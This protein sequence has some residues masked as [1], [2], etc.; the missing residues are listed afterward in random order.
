MEKRYFGNIRSIAP[1]VVCPNICL[2]T[3]VA[4]MQTIWTQIRLLQQSSLMRVH[5][6]WYRYKI[7]WRALHYLADSIFGT[8]L[9]WQDKGQGTKIFK[10]CTCP[11]V[12]VTYNF[13]LS[14]KHM[15]LSFISVC[16]K[17]QKGVIC[18]MTSSS[19]FSQS[20]HPVGRVLWEELLLLS[21]LRVTSRIFVP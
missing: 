13:H 12:R 20:T 15:H 16:N 11:A 18:N 7:V 1:F 4:F 6:D 10:Y 5:S 2:C 19:Y 3:L 9:H 8:K 17:E 14:C 21:R